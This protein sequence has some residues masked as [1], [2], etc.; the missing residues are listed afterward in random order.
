MPAE[1]LTL[2]RRV[3]HLGF[4]FA[5]Q[6]KE[7][8]FEHEALCLGLAARRDFD[9]VRAVGALGS[10]QIDERAARAHALPRLQLD[11]ADIGNVIAGVDGNALSSH[12][13]LVRR[14][15]TERLK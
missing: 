7:R 8:L 3:P 15:L 11:L 5:L 13:L 10:G 9:D 1:T 14:L 4:T 12:P 6:H 2:A